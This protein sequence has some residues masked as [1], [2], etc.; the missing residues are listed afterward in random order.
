MNLCQSVIPFLHFISILMVLYHHL[1]TTYI[2]FIISVYFNGLAFLLHP[3]LALFRLHKSTTYRNAAA[4]S[5][6]LSCL[7]SLPTYSTCALLTYVVKYISMCAYAVYFGRSPGILHSLLGASFLCCFH[8]S[9]HLD[10]FLFLS[11]SLSLSL[12]AFHCTFILNISYS[13]FW[14]G[15]VAHILYRH[16]Y[17]C[18]EIRAN[19]PLS[20]I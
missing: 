12:S 13:Y 14:F 3:L 7:S 19:L 16:T 2:V 8:I 6:H 17:A 1:F 20:I 5:H 4:L 10:P 11:L 18:A 9:F 15:A